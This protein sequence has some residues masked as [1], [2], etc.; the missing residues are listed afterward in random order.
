MTGSIPPPPVSPHAW[1]SQNGWGVS[2]DHVCIPHK[3]Q[4]QPFRSSDMRTYQHAAPLRHWD[5]KTVPLRMSITPCLSEECYYWPFL[6]VEAF[7]WRIRCWGALGISYHGWLQWAGKVTCAF[8]LSFFLSLHQQHDGARLVPDLE[9][10][11]MF[12][13][14]LKQSKIASIKISKSIYIGNKIAKKFNL[15][16]YVFKIL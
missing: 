10:F 8:F 13:Q 12:T 5:L 4:L 11:C 2:L 9:Q 16:E 15:L 1:K 14:N 3:L 6:P 7:R